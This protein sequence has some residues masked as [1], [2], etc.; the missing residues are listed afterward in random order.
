MVFG[1]SSL[2]FSSWRTMTYFGRSLPGGPWSW[3]LSSLTLAAQHGAASTRVRT[4]TVIQDQQL[5]SRHRMGTSARTQ[6]AGEGLAR[7]TGVTHGAA[8]STMRMQ[9]MRAKN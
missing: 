3:P 1:G 6:E 5:G 8:R 7:D 2:P 9:M 4:P